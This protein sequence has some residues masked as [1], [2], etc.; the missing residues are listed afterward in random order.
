MKTSVI[1]FCTDVNVFVAKISVHILNTLILV[2]HT[3]KMQAAS[4]C[5]STSAWEVGE[6]S[7]LHGDG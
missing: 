5:M 2:G 1:L 3:F 4:L 7:K 6:G